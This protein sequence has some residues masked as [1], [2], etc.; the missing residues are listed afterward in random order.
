MGGESAEGVHC[1]GNL[2][3]KECVRII[4]RT[5]RNR[6]FWK[7]PA[8]PQGGEC[9]F[10]PICDVRIR[11]VR[12]KAVMSARAGRRRLFWRIPPNPPHPTSKLRK[13]TEK[14]G[15]IPPESGDFQ[16]WSALKRVER[17]ISPPRKFQARR[18]AFLALDKP[19]LTHSPQPPP[20]KPSPPNLQNAHPRPSFSELRQGAFIR[21]LAAGIVGGHIDRLPA[22]GNRNLDGA[23]SLSG[24]ILCHAHPSRISGEPVKPGILSPL[25]HVFIDGLSGESAG[26]DISISPD[27]PEE[28]GGDEFVDSGDW[29]DRNSNSVFRLW[30]ER[31][32]FR[33]GGRGGF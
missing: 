13:Q 28:R 20:N 30:Q 26:L 16:G 14:G 12:R 18:G 27:L 19:E 3:R 22:S 32:A 15:K 4:R 25:P 33:M 17:G 10:R 6:K 21:F 2:S 9:L 8:P 1:G 7:L 23:D 11:L 29:H 31:A 24:E 5:R